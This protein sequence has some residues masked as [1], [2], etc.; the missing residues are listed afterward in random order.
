[1]DDPLET[2]SALDRLTERVDDIEAG[3]ARHEGGLHGVRTDVS[4]LSGDVTDVRHEVAGLKSEVTDTRQTLD[5]FI[6]QYGR[7]REVAKAQA[8]LNRLTTKWH[9]D[10][11]QRKHTRALARG[12]VHTLTAQAVHR[13]VVN[14]ATVRACTEERMLLEPTY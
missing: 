7:D 3:Q 13:N 2:G 6:E 8:E 14:T 11:A 4:R 10:F 5:T 9:A 1:M 12:L